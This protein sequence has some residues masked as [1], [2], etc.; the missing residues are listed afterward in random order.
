MRHADGERRLTRGSSHG[1]SSQRL[2]SI[3][4]TV[5]SQASRVVFQSNGEEA[6]DLR[7]LSWEEREQ[8]ARRML[9][10]RNRHPA[11][12]PT[13]RFAAPRFFAPRPVAPRLV[14]PGLFPSRR[15]PPN[16]PTRHCFDIGY[17]KHSVELTCPKPTA[18][19]HVQNRSHCRNVC[20]PTATT[21]HCLLIH[22]VP[23]IL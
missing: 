4:G 5:A 3:G 14:A 20:T 23:V 10:P 21:V 16:F 19:H 9:A 2:P 15:L 13:P 1:G 18:V 6:V 17:E 8:V 12:S 11:S 22:N 7:D